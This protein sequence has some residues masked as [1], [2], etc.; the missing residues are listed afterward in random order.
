MKV[1]YLF[2]NNKKIGSK[3]ISWGSSLLVKGLE[4]YP[5]HVAVLLDETFVIESTVKTGVRLVPYEQWKK[6][7][8]EICKIP[9]KIEDYPLPL[10]QELL[11]EVWGKKYDKLGLIFFG[12]Q[13][14]K[15][16]LF[17]TPIAIKNEWEQEDRFFCTEFAGRVAGKDYSMTSPAEMLQSF[18][19]ELPSSVDCSASDNNP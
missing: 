3:I 2:S 9:C 7:N 4:E 18:L 16:W 14:L 10:V 15:H 19:T 8:N 1:S 5:S 12:W 17:K 6:I 11:F 13:I